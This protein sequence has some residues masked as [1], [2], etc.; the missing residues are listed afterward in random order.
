MNN[1]PQTTDFPP[2]EITKYEEEWQQHLRTYI[3]FTK[4]TTAML[5]LK[6]TATAKAAKLYSTDS[7]GCH[8]PTSLL[9]TYC[10]TKYHKTHN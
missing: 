2:S 4:K 10:A 5:Y 3:S 6:N 9:E 7:T 1:N 8:M